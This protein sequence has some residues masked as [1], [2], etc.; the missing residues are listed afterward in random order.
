MHVFCM[1]EILGMKLCYVVKFLAIT[2]QGNIIL[3]I[4]EGLG[5]DLYKEEILGETFCL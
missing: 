3:L 4:M 2:Q 1:Y 5:S